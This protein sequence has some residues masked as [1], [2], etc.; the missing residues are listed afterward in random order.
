[1][2]NQLPRAGGPGE[3]HRLTGDVFAGG[4]DVLRGYLSRADLTP[5]ELRLIPH[6]VEARVVARAL[7]S[8]HR[9]IQ[10]PAN[11]PYLLRN[12]EP[13]WAQLDWFGEHSMAE[14]SE[15]LS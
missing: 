4:R 5:A 6:L 10:F 9:A 2:L 1:L 15:C 11:A 13:G 3:Q 14:V 8:T 7:I 12:T